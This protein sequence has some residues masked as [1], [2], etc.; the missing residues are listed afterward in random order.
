MIRAVQNIHNILLKN[1]A[2][3]GEGHHIPSSEPVFYDAAYQHLD[4]STYDVDNDSIITAIDE[5]GKCYVPEMIPA[6][7]NKLK[8][9]CTKECKVL[10]QWQIDAIIA[11][12]AK[13]DQ[14]VKVMRE[15][16]CISSYDDCP[17]NHYVKRLRDN[18]AVSVIECLGHPLICHSDDIGCTNILRILRAASVHYGVLR[19]ILLSVIQRK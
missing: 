14:S 13:F 9:K 1:K 16:L 2:D 4:S 11:F 10:P 5:H 18:D 15:A 3:F 19:N 6:K 12:R 17:N 8:W 7:K